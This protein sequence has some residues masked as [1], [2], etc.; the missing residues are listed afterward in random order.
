MIYPHIEE[1]AE[2]LLKESGCFSNPININKCASYLNISLVKHQLSDDVSGFIIAKDDKTQIGY[3][4]NHSEKRNRFTI[5]H[6]IGHYILHKEVSKFFIDNFNTP[7]FRDN[8]SSSGEIAREKQANAF[9][10]ALLM[11]A[12]LIEKEITNYYSKQVTKKIELVDALATH[13]NVSKNA[14]MF[15]LINLEKIDLGYKNSLE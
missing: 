2:I 11:P 1:R 3:N 9:A 13:F 15:R 4:A 7:L 5:A 14:M 6:E 10:A 8:S 12:E